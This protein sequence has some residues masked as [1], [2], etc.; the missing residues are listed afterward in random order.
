LFFYS[1]HF[2]FDD[3][4][5]SPPPRDHVFSPFHPSLRRFS[6]RNE[7]V[8]PE[9]VHAEILRELVRRTFGFNKRQHLSQEKMIKERMLPKTSDRVSNNNN[10]LLLEQA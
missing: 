3:S 4:S 1:P 6:F 9:P 8:S 2:I 7:E 5:Y 10:L